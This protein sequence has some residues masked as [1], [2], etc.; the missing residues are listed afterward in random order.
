MNQLLPVFRKAA[1]D[2]MNA[3]GLSLLDGEVFGCDAFAG[4][5]WL[6]G[7]ADVFDGQIQ[8]ICDHG[9]RF[10]QAD[11]LDGARLY[12]RTKFIHTQARADFFL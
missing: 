8:A 4:H 5:F 6:D 1:C 11:V 2:L 12:L 3:G 7:F 10:R 9:N